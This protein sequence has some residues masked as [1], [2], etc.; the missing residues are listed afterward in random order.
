MGPPRPIRLCVDA[1]VEEAGAADGELVEG[2][3][4]GGGIGEEGGREGGRALVLP[5]DIANERVESAG[6]ASHASPMPWIVF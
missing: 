6:D 5:A 3:P 2:G 1:G 4:A